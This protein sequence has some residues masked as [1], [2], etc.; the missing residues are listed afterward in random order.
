MNAR[1]LARKMSVVRNAAVSSASRIERET[2]IA[3]A[4]RELIAELSSAADRS[5]DDEIYRRHRSELLE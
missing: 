5:G 2:K 3:R 1:F 4:E